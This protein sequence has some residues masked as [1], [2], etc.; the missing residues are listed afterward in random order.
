MHPPAVVMN[1]FYTGLGIARSLGE[2]G[3]PVIGLTAQR[4]IY[5]NHTRYAKTVMSPDSRRE[6][7]SLLTFLLRMGKQ[8]GSRGVLF[9]TR[10]DDVVFLDRFREELAPYYSIVAPES[11]ALAACLDKWRTYLCAVEAGVATPKCWLIRSEEDLAQA[12]REAAYP[13]VLKPLAAHHWRQGD[14]WEIVG[15]RKAVPVQS[16]EVLEAEYATICR[17][18]NRALLQEMI[19][20]PDDR[21]LVTACYI[22]RQF[23]LAGEFNTQKLIQ[24]PEGFGTGCVVQSAHQPELIEPT[25]RLL[26]AMKFSG[27]AEVE[28]KW[29]EAAHSYKL[30]EVNPRPWDQHMLGRACGVDL[31]HLAYCDHAGL[32]MPAVSP[33]GKTYKWIADDAFLMAVLRSL[34]RR[35]GRTRSLLHAAR[36][37][38]IYSI[39]SAKDPLPFLGYFSRRVIPQLA[40]ASLRQAWSRLNGRIARR[41]LPA[42][43]AL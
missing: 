37:A 34:K 32:P 29:D 3:I 9:P 13:C 40:W 26:E 8:L 1:M 35:D 41:T 2:R 43:G 19:S 20:G 22:D 4:G 33:S 25:V 36:G 16:R 18:D 6:P 10:D 23:R 28:Y 11:A 21:L 14:N 5:G 17:A 24:E 38:R 30:I 15:A 12:A 27:I 31:I 7:Q 39:W 42:K